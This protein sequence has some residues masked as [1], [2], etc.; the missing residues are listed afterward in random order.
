MSIKQYLGGSPEQYLNKE[1]LQHFEEQLKGQRDYWKENLV[2][3]QRKMY[4]SLRPIF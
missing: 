2:G 1:F 4:V 3:V